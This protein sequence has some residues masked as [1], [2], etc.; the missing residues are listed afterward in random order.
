MS[1]CKLKV[2]DKVLFPVAVGPY[3]DPATVF[4]EGELLNYWGEERPNEY[5]NASVRHSLTGATHWCNLSTLRLAGP[6]DQA[7]L[8]REIM[9]NLAAIVGISRLLQRIEEKMPPQIAMDEQA[10]VKVVID[11]A[12]DVILDEPIQVTGDVTAHDPR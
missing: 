3:G 7:E 2:G 1:D 9:A 4:A 6:R 5:A 12:V 8:L 10:R 11:E